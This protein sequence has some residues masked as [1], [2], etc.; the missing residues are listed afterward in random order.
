M[1]RPVLLLHH[2]PCGIEFSIPRLETMAFIK[3]IPFSPWD[4]AKK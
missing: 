2:Q 4:S 3:L 1:A